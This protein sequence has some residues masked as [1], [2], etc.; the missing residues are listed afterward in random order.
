MIEREV[1]LTPAG[2]RKLEADLSYLRNVKRK[3]LA[4]A[5]KD[6]LSA[7]GAWDNSTMRHQMELAPWR[8]SLRRSH[9]TSALM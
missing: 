9:A 5:M 8:P 7:G 3:E 4:A 2:L 1:Y 6:A